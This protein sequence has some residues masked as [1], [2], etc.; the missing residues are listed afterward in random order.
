[1]K[2]YKNVLLKYNLMFLHKNTKLCSIRGKK[3]YVSKEII[4]KFIL[5]NYTTIGVI[6][7]NIDQVAPQFKTDDYQV[8]S[9]LINDDNDDKI[10]VNYDN[11]YYTINNL[12]KMISLKAFW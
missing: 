12:I 4:N 10:L 7:S 1:M 5:P 9:V 3:D 8:V 11:Q 6:T 2:K